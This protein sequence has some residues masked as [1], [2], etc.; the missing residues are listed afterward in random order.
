VLAG[1]ALV[2]YP[3]VVWRGLTGASPRV[4][5]LV[6]LLLIAPAALVRLRSRAAGPAR[7]L[8]VLPLVTVAL[9]GLA[10]MLDSLGLVLLVPVAVN[11]T[12]LAVFGAT[13]RRGALPMIERFA[14]LQESEL[15]PAETEWCRLWTVLWC[16]FFAANGATAALLAWLAPLAWWSLYN[17]LLAYVLIGAL[18]L[19][20][21]ILRVRRFPRARRPAGEEPR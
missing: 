11:A 3:L 10:G 5:A 7:G 17:G 12:L 1:L 18:L 6:L 4:L 8:A 15:T 9:F 16:A 2:S 20:E 21:W 19:G 13:L 14:R